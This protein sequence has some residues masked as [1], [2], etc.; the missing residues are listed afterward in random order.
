MKYGKYLFIKAYKTFAPDSGLMQSCRE[1][2]LLITKEGW[3]AEP[4]AR[5]LATAALWVRIQTSLKIIN[6]RHKRW[7]GRHTLALQKNIQ[8]KD[9]ITCRSYLVSVFVKLQRNALIVDFN[10]AG[11]IVILLFYINKPRLSSLWRKQ[12]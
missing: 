12:E 2:S 7:S 11:L 5:Q 3:V 4:V 10:T 8:K 6:G 9:D 1:T